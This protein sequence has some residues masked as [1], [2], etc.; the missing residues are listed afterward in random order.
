[1]FQ[2]RNKFFKK[3]KPKVIEFEKPNTKARKIL[4]Y[5]EAALIL[6][7]I[8]G[9]ALGLI[10]IF[11]FSPVQFVQDNF[12]KVTPKTPVPLGQVEVKDKANQIIELLPDDLF[13][14]KAVQS[15]TEEELW[16]ISNQGTLV[17]FSLN[18][19]AEFQLTTLQN[20]LTK[21][22]IN[23]KKVEKID[24]RFE[25]VIVVYAK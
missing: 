24:F 6:L 3:R 15:R 10:K 7:V 9:T 25:K 1:M 11:K 14:F 5:V 20:L 23:K 21:A 22:K 13:T 18:K 17:I 12:Y 8:V 19:H 16:V 2:N 4:F